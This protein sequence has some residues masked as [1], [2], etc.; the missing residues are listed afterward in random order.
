M[1]FIQ[2]NVRGKT[3][4]LHNHRLALYLPDYAR[5]FHT[6]AAAVRFMK[7]HDAPNQFP[8][9]IIEIAD[10]ELCSRRYLKVGM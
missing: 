2:M 5:R 3:M 8:W 7:R 10:S 1:F 4:Y 9:R 6:E